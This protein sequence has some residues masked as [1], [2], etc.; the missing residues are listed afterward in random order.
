MTMATE[1]GI[2]V[3]HR[4]RDPD[5]QGKVRK[6]RAEV[7]HLDGRGAAGNLEFVGEARILDKDLEHEPILLSFRQ[8]IGALLFDGILRG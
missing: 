2:Q 4:V 8:R 3:Q 7:V 6:S 1:T 5:A